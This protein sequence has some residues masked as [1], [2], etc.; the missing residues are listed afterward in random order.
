MGRIKRAILVDDERSEH[1]AFHRLLR[2]LPEIGEVH[3]FLYADDA[4]EFLKSTSPRP[5]DVVFLD[6][7]MPRMNGFEFLDT[8]GAVFG[9]RLK[10]AVIVMLTTSL[11]PSDR[12]RAD[13]YVAVKAFFNK[14]LDQWHIEHARTFLNE[15]LRRHSPKSMLD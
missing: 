14:P 4:M 1:L 11:D 12:T 8:A 13:D 10:N 3:S 9:E 7:K 6:I 5:D 2:R 15:P